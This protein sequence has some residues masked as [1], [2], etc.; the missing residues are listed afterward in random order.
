[1]RDLLWAIRR[2]IRRLSIDISIFD[3]QSA[4]YQILDLLRRREVTHL[5]DAGANRGQFAH[6]MRLQGYKA[7]IHSFEPLPDAFVE[8]E[9]MAH[10]DGGIR[11]HN[12]ALSDQ[13]GSST[14]FVGSN[15]QTSSLQAAIDHSTPEIGLARQIE[16]TTIRLE[17]LINDGT[18]AKKS[19]PHTVLKLDVQGHEMA[20]LRG[21]GKYI[22]GF[23]GIFLETAIEKMYVGEADFAEII[24]FLNSN[25]YKIKAFKGGYFHP[26]IGN[27]MQIDIL[28]ENFQNKN[29]SL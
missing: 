3:V 25:G 16:V 14:F 4:D 21:C 11:P 15:D 17:D 12:V 23:A 29:T 28:F 9:R 13:T 7:V 10:A 27:L 2:Q 24:N 1:M 26:E 22:C 19:L 20:V 5:I 18:I 6:Y 8:L